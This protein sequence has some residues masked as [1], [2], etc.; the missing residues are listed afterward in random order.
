MCPRPVDLLIACGTTH[1]AL[2]KYVAQ[3]Y[4]MGIADTILLCGKYSYKR[5]GIAAE[6]LP[7]PY[8]EM[9]FET[10]A[11]MMAHVLE[12]NFVPTSALILE[13]SSHSICENACAAANIV[14]RLVLPSVYIG[15]VCQSFAAARTRIFF[16]HFFPSSKVLIFPTDTQNIS[17]SNWHID[18]FS[19][20]RVLLEYDKVCFLE[21]NGVLEADDPCFNTN[22]CSYSGYPQ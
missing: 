9:F 15:V 1:I 18:D 11:D 19:L 17:A 14:S 8:C 12:D 13:R 20:R 2:V 4:H 10:E 3:L 6:N 5:T 22:R 7:S 16:S 21:E